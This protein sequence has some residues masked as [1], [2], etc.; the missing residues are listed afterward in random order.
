MKTPRFILFFALFAV[1][2]AIG[3]G[4]GFV[5]GRAGGAQDG[6][7]GDLRVLEKIFSR[8]SPEPTFDILQDGVKLIKAKYVD[9]DKVE[10]KD[11]VYGAMSGMFKALG[12]PYT[13]FLKPPDAK[14]FQEN[15]NGAFEGIGAEIGIRDDML[16]II[17]PLKDSPA[18]RAGLKPGDKVL[19]VDDTETADLTLDE[20]VQI[21]RGPKGSAVVL[22]IAREGEPDNLKI[23]II[24]DTIKIPNIEWEKKEGGIAY[25]SLYHFTEKA[26][27]DFA[28]VSKEIIQSGERKIAL[29][30]RN[31][32]G[33]FL[34]VA[35]DIAGW[36]LDPDL[37]VVT[38]DRR[39]KGEN[40]VY[41]T[42]GS[43]LL[44]DYPLVIL[45]NKGSASASEI[46]AGA[47]RDHRSV[48]VIG[49]KTF[50][51]GSVQELTNFSDKSSV[52]I[53]VAKW[54]TPSGLSIQDNGIEPDTLLE[55]TQDIFDEKG[56]IQLEKALEVLR[57]L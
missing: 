4:G 17:S 34:E 29:D 13:V 15:V 44:K 22:T 52:K 40:K 47:L 55:M 16:T 28:K 37:T 10:E 36:F 46:L 23:S 56:D 42:R 12:D 1:A 14:I 25:I 26:A 41:A 32:P 20:A 7:A 49:E 30:L 5:L 27:G 6:A 19:F 57:G 21:I 51:K 53:T 31:N 50:G 39:G 33:G 8:T 18:E 2:L 45:V 43:G 11:L 48:Q 3:F 38:E 54:L 24:R 35:V 9:S